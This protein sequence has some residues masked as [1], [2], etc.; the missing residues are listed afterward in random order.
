MDAY[1]VLLTIA[2]VAALGAA[3]LPRM[4]AQHP[5]SFPM[6]YVAL[7]MLLFAL[8]LGFDPPHPLR[9]RELT[10]RLTELGVIVALTGAGLKLDRPVGWR[11]WAPTWR[12]L[13]ITMPLTIAGVFALGWWGLGL[14]PASALL[15]GACLAPTDPVL[16]SDVQVA[17]PNTEEEDEVR[18]TLTSE[19]G[20]N[21]ALAF[22]FT[23]AAIAMAL[24]GAAPAAW[25]GEWLLVDVLYKIVVG[26]ACGWILG[27]ALALLIFRT[28]SQTRLAETTEG[29]TALAITLLAYGITELAAG[30][31]FLAV[32]V[33]ATTLRGAERHHEYHRALHEFIESVERILIAALLVLLGGAIVGGLLQPL[34]WQAALVGLATVFII[35][36]ATGLI[37]LVGSVESVHERAAVAFFGIRGIGSLYYLAYGINEAPI[38]RPEV[39]W[40]F[41][42]FVVLV[43]IV[44]HGIA[45]TPVMR[46]LDRRR[47]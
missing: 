36:P 46:H 37:A 32:F 31:G 14:A 40:A 20:L 38:Q 2:G 39:L 9:E 15:L 12:L 26:I 43:S 30:Y 44:V 19:A 22:P 29:I 47:G 10:E 28:P 34:T 23:N 41:V 5:V 7:G 16:A 21:D 24:A 35:R 42:S 33:A 13:A 17:G 11:R 1:D 4:I 3:L 18:F 6:V 8:P 45:A 27:R 25:I